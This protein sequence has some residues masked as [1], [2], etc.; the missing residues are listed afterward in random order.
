MATRDELRRT[1]DPGARASRPAVT[2]GSGPGPAPLPES[3]LG[4][5]LARVI[6]LWALLGGGVLLLGV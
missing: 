3:G 2:T 4:H 5:L 6:A 1:G